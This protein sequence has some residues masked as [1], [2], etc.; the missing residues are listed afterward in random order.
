MR[1]ATQDVQRMKR[2]LRIGTR[3]VWHTARQKTALERWTNPKLSR[4]TCTCEYG[5]QCCRGESAGVAKPPRER[6]PTVPIRH[7]CI[8]VWSLSGSRGRTQRP[9]CCQP[10][11]A[12][13]AAERVQPSE[14]RE[15]RL[16][17]G[18]RG[19]WR[20]RH[21]GWGCR[22]RCSRLRRHAARHWC[23]RRWW[24]CVQATTTRQLIFKDPVG[25]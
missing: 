22:R 1:E 15:G 21:G 17:W 9:R 5:L 23:S 6:S 8:A 20:R 7:F 13:A 24:W 4:R 16:W 18:G 10:H 14:A 2:C 25:F 3:R 12:P 11:G 19:W